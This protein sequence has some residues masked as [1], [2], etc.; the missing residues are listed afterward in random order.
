MSNGGGFRPP[1]KRRGAPSLLR[2]F[3]SCA[4]FWMSA[5]LL[6]SAFSM[7]FEYFWNC[8]ELGDEPPEPPEEPEPP[9]EPEPPGAAAPP[10]SPPSAPCSSEIGFGFGGAVTVCGSPTFERSSENVMLPPSA[11]WNCE[12][13]FDGISKSSETF[14]RRSVSSS[15][16]T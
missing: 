6:G 7:H 10:P 2:Y 12:R 9:D 8:A 13:W 14:R 11:P 16:P 3:R 5:V 1:P 15:L 4:H